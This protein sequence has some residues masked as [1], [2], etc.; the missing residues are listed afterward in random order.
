MQTVTTISLSA[1]EALAAA[2]VAASCNE[3]RF[4]ASQV[5]ITHCLLAE[6]GVRGSILRLIESCTERNRSHAVGVA[7]MKP[8]RSAMQERRSGVG[9][10]QSSHVQLQER[11]TSMWCTL[12]RSCSVVLFHLGL[13]CLCCV[14]SGECEIWRPCGLRCK[15]DARSL[16]PPTRP[17]PSATSFRSWISCSLQAP[18][19]PLKFPAT[20]PVHHLMAPRGPMIRRKKKTKPSAS[21]WASAYDTTSTACQ[22]NNQHDIRKPV[23]SM[24]DLL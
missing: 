2:F 18:T 7:V 6:K 13:A 5:S 24:V 10:G 12:Q 1:L 17:P 21:L 16:L 9:G 15:T 4:G 8:R 11:R 14:A 3:M 19:P 22:C 23:F 20:L